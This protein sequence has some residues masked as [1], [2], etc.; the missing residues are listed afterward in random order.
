MKRDEM[1]NIGFGL[2]FTLVLH[3]GFHQ[4]KDILLQMKR[5]EIFLMK[6]TGFGLGFTLILHY[7]FHQNNYI[8]LQFIAARL[9]SRL[10]IGLS[11]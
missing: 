10:Q 4:N 6:N 7:G 3:Y 11:S 5:D 1:K 9:V 2:G 8:L